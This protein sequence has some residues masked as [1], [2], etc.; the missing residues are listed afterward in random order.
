MSYPP[1]PVETRGQLFEPKECEPKR[2]PLKACGTTRKNL[3]HF[4]ATYRDVNPVERPRR[5]RGCI[6]GID[7]S[8][9]PIPF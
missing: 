5:P 6:A 8:T 4:D 1:D 3:C 9:A 7:P 2:C